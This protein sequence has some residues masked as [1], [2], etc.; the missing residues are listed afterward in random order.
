MEMK[1]I[2][3]Q[4]PADCLALLDKCAGSMDRNE[5]T[6]LALVAH[7]WIDKEK[8]AIEQE[9]QKVIAARRMSMDKLNILTAITN[10]QKLLMLSA[11]EGSKR[12]AKKGAKAA[13]RR[14]QKLTIAAFPALPDIELPQMPGV[15]G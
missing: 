13:P 5:F 11:M 1:T 6:L 2:E 3:I 4:M 12:S 8:A 15:D 7:I 10:A 14:G 9:W